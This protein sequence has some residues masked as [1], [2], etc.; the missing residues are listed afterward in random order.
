MKLRDAIILLRKQEPLPYDSITVRKSNLG[1]DTYGTCVVDPKESSVLIKVN[2]SISEL[3]Q[4]DSLLHEWAHAML[5]ELP[6]E[7]PK[8]GPLWGVCYARCYV[9]VYED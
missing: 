5:G 2:K 7:F 1:S 6:E 3:A 9:C 4:V 8:H